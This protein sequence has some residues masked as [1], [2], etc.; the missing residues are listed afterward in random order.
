MPALPGRFKE[1]MHC[2]LGSIATY[3]H[4]HGNS[5]KHRARTRL[6]NPQIMPGYATARAKSED[7]AG[8]DTQVKRGGKS[9]V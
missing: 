8:E 2:R 3:L 7:L 6:S 4:R 5:R 1:R 9:E